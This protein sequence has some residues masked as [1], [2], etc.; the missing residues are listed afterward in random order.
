MATVMYSAVITKLDIKN[1]AKKS[2]D[3]KATVETENNS[4]TD[5]QESQ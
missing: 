4:N 5:E 3:E 2:Q 1:I